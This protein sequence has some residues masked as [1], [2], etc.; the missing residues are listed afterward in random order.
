[1][2]RYSLEA[3]YLKVSDV[4]INIVESSASVH[5]FITKNVG[6]GIAYSTNSYRLT[7]LPLWGESEGKVNFEFGGLNMFLT[8]RF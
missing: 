1:M 5:Y 6:L 7:N 4:R 2:A 3:F 8:T